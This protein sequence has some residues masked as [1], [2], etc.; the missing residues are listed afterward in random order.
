MSWVKNE[1]TEIIY[2]A[3]QGLFHGAIKIIFAETSSKKDIYQKVPV[4]SI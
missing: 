4:I 2:T 3:R 1:T